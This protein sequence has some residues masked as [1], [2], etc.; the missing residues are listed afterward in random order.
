LDA[1]YDPADHESRH[2]A[3]A[4]ATYGERSIV[5]AFVKSPLGQATWAAHWYDGVTIADSQSEWTPLQ[6]Q[7]LALGRDEYAESGDTSSAPTGHGA[8]HGSR[9]GF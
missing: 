1:V 9:H 4:R 7:F 6:R 3:Y 2:E 5:E 8:R